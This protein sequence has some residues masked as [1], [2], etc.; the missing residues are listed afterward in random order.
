MVWRSPTSPVVSSLFVLLRSFVIARAR[1]RARAF[2]VTLQ[3]VVAHRVF[4]LWCG[5][6]TH[7]VVRGRRR[8]V[9]KGG[10]A[11]PPLPAFGIPIFVFGC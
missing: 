7:A 6:R 10:R 5:A 2:S 11:S 4:R 1:Y 9:V 3:F 8:G